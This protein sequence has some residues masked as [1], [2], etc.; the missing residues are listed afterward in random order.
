M[1]WLR[2]LRANYA[3]RLIENTLAFFFFLNLLLSPNKYY[4]LYLSLQ[5]HVLL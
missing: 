2:F 5:L 3:L 4:E 1:N